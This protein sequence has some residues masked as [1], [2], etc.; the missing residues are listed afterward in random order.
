MHNE[1]NFIHDELRFG[2]LVFTFDGNSKI[3]AS[4]GT[5]ENPKPNA[6]S[7]VQISD[8]PG[9]TPTCR[10]DCY[11]HGLE[12]YAPDI[13]MAYKINS[14]NMRKVLLRNEQTKMLVSDFSRWI[15]KNCKEFRWH[16]SGDVFSREYANFIKYV[17]ENSSNVLH[18]IYTRTF[19][20]VPD[21]I[22]S[23]NLIVNL[24]ADKDNY[25][26]A[27]KWG[28]QYSL[29]ICYF[30]K[31]G[32]I[33]KDLPNDSVIFPNYFLRGRDLEKPTQ[34]KWWKNLSQKDKKKV[35]PVDFFGQSETRRCGKCTKCLQLYKG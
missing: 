11:V 10:K 21:L 5:F 18:W 6:F 30:S 34:H 9:S 17:C 26:E 4:N 14:V 19:D 8:C 29:R 31:N 28:Q 32:E 25:K 15:R 1:T 13:H 22:A 2:E 35:C 33:P 16:V 7:T 23:K 12:K 3:T 27:K 24:S 20:F